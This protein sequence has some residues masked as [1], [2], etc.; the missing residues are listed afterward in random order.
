[1]ALQPAIYSYYRAY[2]SHIPDVS[3]PNVLLHTISVPIVTFT[4]PLSLQHHAPQNLTST[5]TNA[6]INPLD[7][8]PILP[9]VPRKRQP[10]STNLFNSHYHFRTLRY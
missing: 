7:H 6:S 5:T 3:V 10:H 8:K 1:M 2:L 9:A 4:T